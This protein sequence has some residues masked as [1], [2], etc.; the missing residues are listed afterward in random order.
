MTQQVNLYQQR[1]RPVSDPIAAPRLVGIVL[2]SL[3]VLAALWGW[4]S[5]QLSDARTARAQVAG[6]LERRRTALAELARTAAGRRP[7]ARLEQELARAE[8]MHRVRSELMTLLESGALGTPGGFSGQMRALARQSAAGLWL[9]GFDL[10]AGQV[11]LQGR[12]LTADLVPA[13]LRR[14]GSEKSMEGI[15]FNGLRI[16]TPVRSAYGLQAGPAGSTAGVA[17]DLSA[18]R[19]AA[20]PRADTAAPRLPE[21]VEF[22]VASDARAVE[23]LAGVEVRR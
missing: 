17:A 13:Y 5:W 9:T 3:A 15:S 10:S 18:E 4:S 2:A 20:V 6:A 19:R 7:D 23:T 21:Y 22:I 14:L 8:S 16:A 11:E 12:A 1:F